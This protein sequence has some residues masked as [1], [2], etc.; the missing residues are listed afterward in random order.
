MHVRTRVMPT[1][2]VVLSYHIIFV[3]PGTNQAWKREL[4]RRYGL[5]AECSLAL[6]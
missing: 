1:M 3:L 5:H 6:R 4:E 2:D